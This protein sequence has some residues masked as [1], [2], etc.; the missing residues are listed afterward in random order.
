LR[1]SQP[2][3]VP[4]VL[5]YL[6]HAFPLSVIFGKGGCL[7]WFYSNYIQLACPATYDFKRLIS[8]RREKFDFY[9]HP[10][11]YAVHPHSHLRP[12]PLLESCWFDRELAMADGRLVL[13]LIQAID[14]GYCVEACADEFY[15]PGM[16]C[17]QEQHRTHEIL[18]SGYDLETESFVVSI[19]FDRSGDFAIDEIA[20]SE[21]E[22]AV[23]SADLKG[24]YN[25][26]GIGLMRPARR[27]THTLDVAWIVEQLKDY[28]CSRN[29]SE[30]FRALR[31]P[32][33]RIY[34]RATYG[35]LHRYFEHLADHHD[36]YDIR[37][38]HILWEHK[39]VMADRA[40]YLAARGLID[41]A[42]S[43]SLDE[44]ALDVS[45]TRMMMLK[46]RVM[47]DTALIER[48]GGRLGE[49]ERAETDLLEILVAQLDP[50]RRK[51][52]AD[53]KVDGYPLGSRRES[54]FDSNT[55]DVCPN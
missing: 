41:D 27:V 55:E 8:E 18:I 42:V 25:Q 19:G 49:V 39:K 12:S 21:V 17:Y 33:D 10:D 4:P 11:Y 23:G 37:P 53:K 28:L 26:H 5:G 44:I 14:R 22:R 13:F 48:V 38:I 36:S 47:R 45:V 31:T 9:L 6:H 2:L 43:R 32:D 1:I 52:V 7:P 15:V 54:K 30:R 35:W 16:A 3:K 40:R 46:A 29:T 50:R 24:H 51:T 20:F 34:G